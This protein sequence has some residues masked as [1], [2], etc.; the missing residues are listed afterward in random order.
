MKEAPY[1]TIIACNRLTSVKFTSSGIAEFEGLHCKVH[2]KERHVKVSGDIF[3]VTEGP[4]DLT[5]EGLVEGDF[6]YIK[7]TVEGPCTADIFSWRRGKERES[8]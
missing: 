2:H 5:T 3:K 6:A 7:E 8:C 1:W 4:V